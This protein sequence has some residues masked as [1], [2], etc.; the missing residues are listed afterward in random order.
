MIGAGLRDGNKSF[1]QGKPHVSVKSGSCSVAVGANALKTGVIAA[2]IDSAP[3]GDGGLNARG[4][5][6][7]NDF[8]S[9]VNVTV[10]YEA[11]GAE[12]SLSAETVDGY[13]DTRVL[14]PLW[15]GRVRFCDGGKG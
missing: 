3:F 5:G 11:T 1:F 15:L 10:G 9:A 7:E 12:L 4:I 6:T 2:L 14:N 8:R 13:H